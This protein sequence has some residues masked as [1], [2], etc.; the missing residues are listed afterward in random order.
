MAIGIALGRVYPALGPFHVSMWAIAKS[1]LL[2]LGL[3]L[4]AGAAT[5]GAL[6]HWRGT[7]WYEQ[8]FLSRVGPMALLGLLYTIVLMFAMQGDKIVRLPLDVV[9]IALPLVLYFVIMFGCSFV[10]AKKLGFSYED[11]ASLSFTAAGNNFELAI[12]VSIGLFGIASGE[13][14]AGVVGPLIEVPALLALVYL[15]LWL[16][17]RW[18]PDAPPTTRSAAVAG[19]GEGSSSV[20][21]RSET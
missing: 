20:T 16:K 2:F 5:R 8:R 6:V 18:F 11:T 15:S 9:R 21:A 4:V 1:V 14:L 12:A 3:P 19:L 13:A 17:S 10:L 7:D